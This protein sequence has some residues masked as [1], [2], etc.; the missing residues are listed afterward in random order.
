MFDIEFIGLDNDVRVIKVN[1]F[2]TLDD[3]INKLQRCKDFGL[4]A[5]ALF[6]GIE[7]NNYEDFNRQ[8]IQRKFEA[9]NLTNNKSPNIFV[10]TEESLSSTFKM[11]EEDNTN[12]FLE[13]PKAATQVDFQS[14]DNPEIKTQEKVQNNEETSVTNDL[15]PSYANEE[16]EVLSDEEVQFL[17]TDATDTIDTVAQK[18]EICHEKGLKAIAIL[19]DVEVSNVFFTKAEDIKKEYLKQYSL[20]KKL[21]DHGIEFMPYQNKYIS[22]EHAR[23]RRL[24]IKKNDTIWDIIEKLQYCFNNGI[25][26]YA[27]FNGVELNNYD[28][29]LK[30][31]IDDKYYLRDYYNKK[32]QENRLVARNLE[33]ELGIENLAYYNE[34]NAPTRYLGD[35]YTNDLNEYVNNLRKQ[36][37]NLRGKNYNVGPNVNNDIFKGY[38]IASQTVN[39]PNTHIN[40][41]E[42]FTSSSSTDVSSH[43]NLDNFSSEQRKSI[44]IIESNIASNLKLKPKI[45]EQEPSSGNASSKGKEA[46]SQAKDS[47][48]LKANVDNIKSK[49]R[50]LY[51]PDE[52]KQR[53]ITIANDL[54]DSD[55]DDSSID[56][57][58]DLDNGMDNET[59][60][61]ETSNSPDLTNNSSVGSIPPTQNKQSS[62]GKGK[63]KRSIFQIFLKYKWLILICIGILILLLIIMAFYGSGFNG[64][65]SNHMFGLNGYEYYEVKNLCETVTLY[66]H[67]KT[68]YTYDLDFE[69][70]YIPGVIRGEVGEF[71]DSPDVL[72]LFAIAA[73][74]YALANLDEN[75]MIENSSYKQ[76]YKSS[77]GEDEMQAAKETYGLIFVKDEKLSPIYYDAACYQGEDETHYFIGY[78]R[79]TLGEQQTQ[80]IP[81]EWANTK[82]GLMNY[83]N[84]SK[85][86]DKLCWSNHGRGISQ[87][88]AYYLATQEGYTLEDLI[89]FYLGE[90]NIYSI[91]PGVSNNYLLT[92][93]SGATNQLTKPLRDA[94]QDFNVT[95]EEYNEFILKNIIES[96]FGTKSAVV[97]AA[98]TLVGGLEQN[99]NLRLNYTWSGQHGGT[100]STLTGDTI[101]NRTSG[102]F[103]GVDPNW[104]TKIKKSSNGYGPDCSG[105]V[106]WAIYNAGFSMSGVTST[107]LYR[108]GDNVEFDGSKH[109]EP[110]DLVYSD[111]YDYDANGA[112]VKTGGHIALIVGVDESKKVYYIAQALNQND[113][114]VISTL[115]FKHS[116]YWTHQKIVKMDEFYENNKLNITEEEFIERFRAGYVDGYT[117]QYN[118]NSNLL[119]TKNSLYFVGDSRTVGLCNAGGLCTG[120][121]CDNASCL[122]SVGKGYDW[123]ENNLNKISS[124]GAHNIIINM[125]IN[126]LVSIEDGSKQAEKYFTLIKQLASNNRNKFFYINSINPVGNGNVKKEAVESFNEKMRSLISSCTY[127]NISYLDTYNSLNYDIRSDG[128]HYS[129][130]TYKSLYDYI[131]KEID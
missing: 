84:G 86:N 95:P 108:L 2:D 125:G 131:K 128:I 82:K 6:N 121:E 27:N 18:L 91:Y 28:L 50:L 115:S 22:K 79:N 126:D 49:N 13:P 69:T 52:R 19:N 117:G 30:K 74:T 33:K 54:V 96:G 75:C 51:N 42:T 41:N 63:N 97:A 66:N 8:S 57:D 53:L 17:E 89:R 81:K 48:R 112:Y 15:N 43:N 32:F 111:V 88:G 70:E 101:I 98:V 106:T 24:R 40:S 25:L 73:R 60:S 92:T 64:N 10:Q 94:L 113:G 38:N 109:G 14:A 85:N 45:K 71:L 9:R 47:S 21:K 12:E 80:R 72:K 26:M 120:E 7:I 78:G 107:A 20:E 29:N 23:A 93:S 118:M 36:V 1:S 39:L 124:I 55:V 58:N 11:N 114:V 90:I 46:D 105:F 5:K 129:N 3:V 34:T 104:G 100:F 119:N 102:T 44:G 31:R 56:E 61:N 16:V 59:T 110:G 67:E 87:Y 76:V 123:F 35:N 122:A 99:Y 68:V 77:Y 130:N 103:Y 127:T 4:K 37:I 65:S 62:S 83:V 116:N